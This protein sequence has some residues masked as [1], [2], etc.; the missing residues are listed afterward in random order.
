MK[1]LESLKNNPLL[2]PLKIEDL[3]KLRGGNTQSFYN[4]CQATSVSNCSD[5]TESKYDDNNCVK[6]R[7]TYYDC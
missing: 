4:V 3:S 6:S 7:V 1:S 2:E 5:Y